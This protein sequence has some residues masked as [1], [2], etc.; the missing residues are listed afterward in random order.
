MGYYGVEGWVPVGG[1]YG[2]YHS[3]ASIDSSF[4][5]LHALG[6]VDSRWLVA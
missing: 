5:G 2:I 3:L 6:G 1:W 4:F